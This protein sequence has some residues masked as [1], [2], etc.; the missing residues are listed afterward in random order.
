M[1][2]TALAHE[3]GTGFAGVSLAGAQS[4]W[5]V[6]VVGAGPAGLSA[7]LILG[8]C[9]RRVLICD[10]GTPRSWASHAIHGFVSQDGLPPEEFRLRARSELARYAGVVVCDQAV[11]SARRVAESV[12]SV[13]L[14]SGEE[15]RTRKLLLA[16]GVM[17]ELPPIPGVEEY[18]G[19]SVFP[20]PY[21]DGWELR[22]APIAAFG[23]GKRG[24]ELARSLLAWTPDV[25][26][27]TNGAPGLS[28]S[29]LRSLAANRIA[30]ESAPVSH[31][32]GRDGQLARI[33]F[34][35]G[36]SI[37]RAA[38]FFNLPCHPQSELARAL[39]CQFTA[40]GAIR[41]GQYEAT[42]VPGVFV[43]GNILK[44]VQLSI[45]AA[46][47]GARAAFGINR[48]LTREDFLARSGEPTAVEHP[49]PDG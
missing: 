16:T 40:T 28:R 10:R 15:V 48:A 27:C 26:L 33:A 19:K 20:C 8:R 6:V 37:A 17:D 9:C 34:A 46:A 18:F 12:F 21:C 42:S 14:D 1:N 36:R 4:A 38:L 39:G 31:L 2:D 35:D 32:E 5:D 43:A 3:S 7:A 41:C 23:R 45:V 30:I 25:A 11:V 13:V 44:D 24:F 47:E 22:N 29:D 49:G